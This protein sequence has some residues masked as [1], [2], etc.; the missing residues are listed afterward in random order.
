MSAAASSS[1]SSGNMNF[2]EKDRENDVRVSNIVAAK[3]V[4]DAVRTSLGPRGADKML[5]DGKGDVTISNDGATIMSK[6]AVVHPVA[7]MLVELS[8]A[9]DVEAGDGTTS[10]VVLAGSLLAKSLELLE[11]GVHPTVIAEGYQ[12]SL[13][14]AL[15]VLRGMALP[16]TLDDRESLLKAAS[17]SLNSKIVSQYSSLLAPIA[18]DAVLKV[19]NPELDNNVDLNEIKVVTKLGG[20]VDDTELVEGLVFTKLKIRAKAGGP[21]KVTNAKIGLIQFQLSPPKTDMENHI[22]VSSHVQMDRIIAQER[23]D[24]LKKVKAIKK[25]GCNVLLIQKSILRDAVSDLAL[26]YLSKMK[27]LVV[28]DV[29]RADVEFICDTVGCSPISHIDHMSAEKLGTAG[30]VES[31]GTGANRYIKITDVPNPGKTVT[32]LCRGSNKLMLAEAE[33][34]I[35][36]ALCVIRSLVKERF[37]VAGGGAPEMEVSQALDKHSRTIPG[38]KSYCMRAFAEAMEIIPY[39]L[40]ENAGLSPIKIVTELRNQH[41][42]GNAQAGINVRRGSITNMV[43]DAVIQPLLVSV[44]ALKLAVEC[45]R[46][47]CKIDEIVSSK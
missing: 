22:I 44:S 17:T 19:I 1:K 9:Q 38:V 4:A 18:V 35:H 31:L 6:M 23:K 7:K 25:S 16:L 29:E 30:T 32:I 21:Q 37:L 28:T 42:E 10:V 34:S 26:H 14:Y 33:R 24:V 13:D 45:A 41:A 3:A 20:T 12:Q 39:T 46:G 5:V 8:R 27:I 36:D 11:K 40:A 15:D 2:Q 47:I 43:D